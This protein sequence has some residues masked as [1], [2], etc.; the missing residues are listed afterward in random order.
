VGAVKKPISAGREQIKPA[1]LQ[2][3]DQL[4]DLKQLV[5]FDVGLRDTQRTVDF[6]IIDLEGRLVILRHP[7]K[8]GEKLNWG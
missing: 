6:D 4:L 8:A 3:A 2:F 7:I 5:L 1:V